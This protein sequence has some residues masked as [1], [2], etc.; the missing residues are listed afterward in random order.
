MPLIWTLYL[1]EQGCEDLW[2]FFEAKMGPRAKK[3]GKYFYIE[4]I[5]FGDWGYAGGSLATCGVI[6]AEQVPV[7][8]RDKECPTKKG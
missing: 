3:F 4:Y 7:E 2:L 1:R 8:E 5:A 6:Q